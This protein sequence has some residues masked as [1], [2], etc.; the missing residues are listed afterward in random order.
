MKT[1]SDDGLPAFEPVTLKDLFVHERALR[2]IR[3]FR[4]AGV[5]GFHPMY[6][7]GIALPVHRGGPA[8]IA[9]V[10]LADGRVVV[11]CHRPWRGKNIN[12]ILEYD[13]DGMS[14]GELRKYTAIWQHTF[15]GFPRLVLET[16]S[17]GE[18]A[19][20][21]LERYAEVAAVLAEGVQFCVAHP[22]HGSHWDPA[23]AMVMS[24]R[25]V[26][27]AV[28][29]F[30]PDCSLVQ[31]LKLGM[32][33]KL[34]MTS[35]PVPLGSGPAEQSAIEPAAEPTDVVPLPPAP[36]LSESEVSRLVNDWLGVDKGYLA[37][38]SYGS[39]DS[40]WYDLCGLVVD[41]RG[42]PGTTRE[43]FIETLSNTTPENQA[44]VVRRILDLYPT[45]LPP[46][47]ERPYLRT[48]HFERVVRTW[49]VRLET[50][51]LIEP[52]TLASATEVVRR[53]LVDADNLISTSGPQSAVDRL[54]T[55]L[56]GYLITMASDA[57]IAL[58]EDRPTI[59]KLLKVLRTEHPALADL[60]ARPEDVGRILNGFATI[61]DALNPLRNNASVAHPG[62]QLVGEAEARLVI[63][64]V[65]T[66]LN[67]LEDRRLGQRGPTAN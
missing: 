7:V 9:L 49:L 11:A 38:F 65:R 47:P 62:R 43:C 26:V 6:M 30:T 60:G 40:F 36:R 10:V 8:L 61:F 17:D 33:L 34:A 14:A 51:Q 44:R 2:G 23:D 20:A 42:F 19:H 16:A 21:L 25:G 27:C 66:V 55:A 29:G 48:L 63:N 64:T 56:H 50:G 52:V 31:E 57:G 32:D 3:T 5:V 58:S 53:A 24:L 45:C 37:D 4:S 13:E 22:P 41:T 67:Y 12:K 28:H 1:L 39:H 54:H 15:G 35:P 46:D 59:N 18:A